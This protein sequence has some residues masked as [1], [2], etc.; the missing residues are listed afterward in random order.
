MT[1]M[2]WKWKEILLVFDVRL[3]RGFANS[4]TWQKP[5]LDLN[6]LTVC[7]GMHTYRPHNL[8]QIAQS[9]YDGRRS[10]RLE[11]FRCKTQPEGELFEGV[12]AEVLNPKR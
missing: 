8:T 11:T 5:S 1:A 7:N 2:R 10:E 4:P 12:T 6:V 3:G 9:L